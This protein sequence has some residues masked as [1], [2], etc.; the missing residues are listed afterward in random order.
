MR[1]SRKVI[2]QKMLLYFFLP[3]FG[4]CNLLFK[5]R[6]FE[7]WEKVRA[8]NPDSKLWDIG[9]VVGSMWR[10]LP[11]QGKQIYFDEYEI[12]KA[13]YEKSFK[14]Y[15]NSAAYVAYEQQNRNKCNPLIFCF[16]CVFFIP[17]PFYWFS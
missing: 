8:S 3:K 1:Y 9:K 13:E 12:E 4:G 10:E 2:K 7:M 15:K 17:K 6:T 14:A 16:L 11:D 5:F